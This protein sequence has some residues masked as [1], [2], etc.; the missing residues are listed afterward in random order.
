MSIENKLSDSIDDA[1]TEQQGQTI[2]FQHAVVQVESPHPAKIRIRVTYD[3]PAH[4]MDETLGGYHAELAEAIDAV[5]D[6]W[7]DE[8][9]EIQRVPH[10][11]MYTASFEN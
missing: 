9:K 10:N 5:T 1:F 11:S 8:T 7:F 3:E 6:D 4:G 2:D